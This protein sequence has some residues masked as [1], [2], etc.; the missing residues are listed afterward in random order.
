MQSIYNASYL[1]GTDLA[2]SI[3][4]LS[5]WNLLP[6]LGSHVGNYN[7][8]VPYILSNFCLHFFQF[9]LPGESRS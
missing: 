9:Y 5:I 2:I 6:H 4:T 1:V 8:P 3:V 7:H